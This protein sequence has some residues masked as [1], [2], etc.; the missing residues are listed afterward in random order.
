MSNDPY[1]P[2][3]E[4]YLA[5]QL[6]D[7]ERTDLEKALAADT[8]LRQELQRARLIDRVL[9]GVTRQR[10]QETMDEVA[11]EAGPLPIPELSWWDRLRFALGRRGWVGIA[12]VSLLVVFVVVGMNR[13]CP[14]GVLVDSYFL[15][16]TLV[17]AQAG[18]V[19]DRNLANRASLYYA[20][21]EGDELSKLTTESRDVVPLYYLA[22]DYLRNDD[23]SRA[24]STFE[25]L[26]E[27]QEELTAYA[28]YQDLDR[29][30]F[31]QILSEL[32]MSN[33]PDV[34]RLAIEKLL[35]S[36]TMVA[37]SEIENKARQLAEQLASGWQWW[38][39]S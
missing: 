29:L 19:L 37:G 39:C 36:P 22:H 24:E 28:E 7:R 18:A 10:L 30:R 20:T 21:A 25:R 33:D 38:T 32:G 35:V 3:I 11:A 27:R 23:Y 6:S 15:A 1:D 5:G 16:P 13:P 17:H 9:R 14:A 4:S 12:A 8:G 26:F 34:A 31:N 2:R